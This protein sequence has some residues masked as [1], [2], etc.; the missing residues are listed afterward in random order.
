MLLAAAIDGCQV[1]AV[2]GATCEN[3]SDCAANEA[4]VNGT[5]VGPTICNT[6][7]QCP[8][9][10]ICGGSG[11]CEAEPDLPDTCTVTAN[12]PINAYCNTALEQP[13][14]VALQPGACREQ[15]QC[16]GQVCSALPG[17][18]GRCVDCLRNSDCPSNQ[19]LSTG[20]CAPGGN[21]AG[22]RPDA[23][24]GWDAGS[25]GDDP[26]C[27]ADS[28]RCCGSGSSQQTQC[29]SSNMRCLNGFPGASDAYCWR[30]CNAVPCNTLEGNSGWCH[31]SSSG[32]GSC[33]GVQ[34]YTCSNS[35]QCQQVYPSANAACVFMTDVDAYCF[36][37]GCD[38]QANCGSGYYCSTFDGNL[39]LAV[40]MLGG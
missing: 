2:S 1:A 10:Q 30:S 27:G 24:T 13:A 7:D 14:C 38:W 33:Q 34:A 37:M 4:C 35:Y 8:S 22:V 18:V 32:D 6:D 12:C 36:D 25:G 28:Q 21:D 40:S 3:V 17:G 9:G 20:T 5:C 19:C 29:D 39:C 23:A 15:S 26:N 31:I 11:F 16:S